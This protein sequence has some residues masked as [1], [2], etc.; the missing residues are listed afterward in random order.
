MATALVA[1]CSQTLDADIRDESGVVVKAGSVPA[2]RLR[3]GD[4]IAVSQ[5]GEFETIPVV[6]C[7][8]RHELQVFAAFEIDEV[9][10]PG[11]NAVQSIA[12]VR[13]SNEFAAAFGGRDDFDEWGVTNFTPLEVG[14]RELN[15]REVLCLV[16]RFDGFNTIDLLGAQ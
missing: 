12:D 11:D 10:F 3:V 7:N 1:G 16:G 9:D 6:P 8:E 14:W 13:C 15:D 2:L 5:T 4:C